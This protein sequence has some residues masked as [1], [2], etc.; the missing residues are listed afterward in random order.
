MTTID[1]R[2]RATAM[3]ISNVLFRATLIGFGLLRLSRPRRQ[4][5]SR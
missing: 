3:L 2:T 4:S 1:D 5:S